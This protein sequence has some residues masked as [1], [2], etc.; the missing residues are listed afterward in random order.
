MLQEVSGLDM[1][2]T[3]T[4]ESSGEFV[5]KDFAHESTFG[6]DDADVDAAYDSHGESYAHED[7]DVHQSAGHD[8]VAVNGETDPNSNGWYPESYDES[9]TVGEYATN[10]TAHEHLKEGEGANS[11]EI[12][13]DGI[14]QEFDEGGVSFDHQG[15]PQ[16]EYF[17]VANGVNGDEADASGAHADEIPASSFESVDSLASLEHD[18]TPFAVAEDENENEAA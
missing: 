6:Q 5:P 15:A 13:Y 8:Q 14:F 18:E 7:D 9:D 17:D 10:T 16:E 3:P 11:A 4:V 1:M 2:A 12:P